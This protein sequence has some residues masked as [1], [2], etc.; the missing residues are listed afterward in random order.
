MG[1]PVPQRGKSGCSHVLNGRKLLPGVNGKVFLRMIRI[2]QEIHLSDL[3]DTI[4]TINA[5]QKPAGLPGTFRES[6][7][8]NPVKV[9]PKHGYLHTPPEIN[10]AL[11]RRQPAHN[12]EAR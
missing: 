12:H 1:M 5:G 8:V 7:P 4:R 2:G 10:A 11:I 3:P 9:G 6:M